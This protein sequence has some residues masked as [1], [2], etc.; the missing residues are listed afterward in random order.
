MRSSA[1]DQ[2]CVCCPPNTGHIF[3]RLID[4]DK[5]DTRRTEHFGSDARVFVDSKVTDYNRNEGKRVRLTVDV[6]PDA[7]PP[8]ESTGEP[9]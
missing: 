2:R 7:T 4:W 6:L 9:Q 5:Y 1:D 8:T 3:G